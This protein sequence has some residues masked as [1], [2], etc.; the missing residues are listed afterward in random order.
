MPY[1]HCC[2]S[3]LTR[4]SPPPILHMY[5]RSGRK[6]LFLVR[7]D[8]SR[9]QKEKRAK[10]RYALE[11]RKMQK[12]RRMQKLKNS[13]GRGRIVLGGPQTLNQLL[14]T[15]STPGPAL[16]D[17]FCNSSVRLFSNCS[18]SIAS[19]CWRGFS[20]YPAVGGAHLADMSLT[21]FWDMGYGWVMRPSRRISIEGMR[22]L[23]CGIFQSVSRRSKKEDGE[24]GG[25][26]PGTKYAHT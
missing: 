18:F 5:P 11:S 14:A 22:T 25:G 23:S 2:V 24:G 9:K 16:F 3:P 8:R 21:K 7:S 26:S 10:T 20:L 4:P 15:Y 12:T 6:F 13:R 19:R 17:A 1:W